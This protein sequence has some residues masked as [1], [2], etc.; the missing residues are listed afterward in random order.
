MIQQRNSV[1]GHNNFISNFETDSLLNESTNF[2]SVWNDLKPLQVKNEKAVIAAIQWLSESIYV[3]KFKYTLKLAGPARQDSVTTHRVI[4]N[5]K[6][7]EQFAPHL[8]LLRGIFEFSNPSLLFVSIDRIDQ[9]VTVEVNS[10]DDQVVTNY[11]ETVFNQLAKEIAFK[12]KLKEI[13]LWEK[14][15]REQH[16][17]VY[18][19]LNTISF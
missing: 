6:L 5:F 1:T 9:M 2:Q 8:V 10:D 19:T 7:V 3:S 4:L 15:V 17:F 12:A 13:I 11:L 18:N 16:S 14:S